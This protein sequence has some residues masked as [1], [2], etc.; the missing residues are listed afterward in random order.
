MRILVCGGRDFGEIPMK[1]VNGGFVCDKNHPT[2]SE[3]YKER[4]F[5]T[6]KLTGLLFEL[7]L[8]TEDGLGIKDELTIIEGECPTGVDQ[9][10]VEWAVV[11]WTGLKGYPADWIQYG[12]RA[13]YIRNQQ[14]LT[15]GKPDLVVAFPGG[16]GT[17]MMVSLAEKAGVPVIQYTYP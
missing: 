5:V 13:G 10:A 2:W 3:K 4:Y 8:L 7:N 16:R 15:E 12:K 11:N 1:P 14:M 9:I 6:S 17:K